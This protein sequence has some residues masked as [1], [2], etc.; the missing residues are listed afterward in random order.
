VARVRGESAVEAA[1]REAAEGTGLR[2]RITGHVGLFTDSMHVVEAASGEEIRQQFV[3]CFHA[4]A[5]WGRPRPDGHETSDAAWFDP[6]D[7]ASLTLEPGARR[8]VQH[9]LSGA[10]EPYLE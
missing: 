9:A 7:V 1:V 10:T 3:V 2:V 5:I 6:E 8:F 4:W